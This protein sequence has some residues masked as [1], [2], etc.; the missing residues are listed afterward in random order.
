MT[1]HALPSLTTPEQ[2]RSNPDL[3]QWVRTLLATREGQLFFATLRNYCLRTAVTQPV[4]GEGAA[5]ELGRTYGR[6][7][8]LDVALV[9]G[10]PHKQQSFVEPTYPTLD[11][12]EPTAQ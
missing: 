12:A 5:F 8:L 2:F 11:T 4:T 9:L 7:E 1:T 3:V 6:S 10:E